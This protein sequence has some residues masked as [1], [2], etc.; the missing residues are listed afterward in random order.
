MYVNRA[1]EPLLLEAVEQFPAVG[2]TGPRQAGKS[3]LVQTCLPNYRYI[4]FDDPVERKNATQD[5]ALF[6]SA[7]PSPV[8]LDEIQYVPDLIPLIKLAI[9]QNRDK[10][11]QYILTGSQ[12]FPLMA[13]VS[14][15]L[16]GRIALFA[17][18]PLSWEELP[19]EPAEILND[20]LMIRRMLKG[21]YPELYRR[22]N[23]NQRVWLQSYIRTYLDRDVRQV[24]A[25]GDLIQ[26]QTFLGLLAARAGQLLNLSEVAR[27]CQISQPTAKRW[28]SVLEATYVIFLLKPYARN[29][30]KRLIKSPKVYFVDTGILCHL[31]GIDSE[32]L[33]LNS[34]FRGHLFENMVVM[35]WVKRKSL[36]GD[37]RFLSFYRTQ[38]GLEIDLLFHKADRLEAYE[39]KFS[40]SPALRMVGPLQKFEKEYPNSLCHLLCLREKK[41]ALTRTIDAIH[42]SDMN[43]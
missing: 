25:I 12:T 4:S 40:K 36:T 6:L 21:F 7:N 28:L 26:F 32:E 1:I 31:L 15:S 13:G 9:D 39:I 34:P 14:E 42:W 33:I 29:H 20:R 27:E 2:I 41:L 30:T 10:M 22:K 38:R 35:E 43:K 11:G 23:I 37:D 3:T 8:I 17:L 19:H 18:Y 5:P 24:Q 16:A